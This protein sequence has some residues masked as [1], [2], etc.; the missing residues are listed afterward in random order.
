[1]D[2]SSGQTPVVSQSHV[3][4]GFYTTC[5]TGWLS[6]PETSVPIIQSLQGHHTTGPLWV[7]AITWV[8]PRWGH[9]SVTTASLPSLGKKIPISTFACSPR[10]LFSPFLSGMILGFYM[11]E[12]TFLTL[13]SF[14]FPMYNKLLLGER[15]LNVLPPS[16]KWGRENI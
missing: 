16:W 11:R 8:L 10:A 3:T 6:K 14:S 12:D 1:M 15:N 9:G 4:L 2:N 13:S 5:G 7:A